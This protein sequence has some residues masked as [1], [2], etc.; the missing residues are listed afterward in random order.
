MLAAGPIGPGTP[1]RGC[2]YRR[3][4]CSTTAGEAGRRLRASGRGKAKGRSP[5]R[6]GTCRSSDPLRGMHPPLALHYVTHVVG[7]SAIATY[8]T[9]SS[10]TYCISC[11]KGGRAGHPRRTPARGFIFP[12]Q[13]LGPGSQASTL[14]KTR[15]G[16]NPI[17]LDY[18]YR[19]KLK[20]FP[21][22]SRTIDKG[23]SLL[24]RR[25]SHITSVLIPPSGDAGMSLT[26]TPLHLEY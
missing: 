13:R 6:W 17:T 15:S 11:S 26:L 4:L 7:A 12:L 24:T 3:F 5:G 19:W 18:R 10:R 2:L 8:R 16:L 21:R 9:T 22:C 14:A 1:K 23:A 20:T 25:P